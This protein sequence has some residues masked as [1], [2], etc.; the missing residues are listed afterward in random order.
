MKQLRLFDPPQ[1]I[2]G[3]YH[4]AIEKGD[5]DALPGIILSLEKPENRPPD[6]QEKRLFWKEELSG[7]REN[8][9]RSA[10][11][12]ASYWE[13]LLPRLQVEALKPEALYLERHWFTLL[14][15]KLEDKEFDY[16]TRSLHPVLCLLRIGQH[17][18]AIEMSLEIGS[19]DPSPTV[20]R[21]YRPGT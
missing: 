11:E 20:N 9:N 10:R 2:L 3:H 12:M 6:W 16:L 18:R 21:T 5:W 4:R 1:M 15:D 14:T 19:L 13:K 7:L 17:Q 8:E